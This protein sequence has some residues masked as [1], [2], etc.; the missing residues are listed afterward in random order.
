[1]AR[2]RGA[3]LPQQY[4]LTVQM[5]LALGIPQSALIIPD[6]V[7]DNTAAE[8]ATLREEAQK[9]GWKRVIVVSSAYHLRRV[10]LACR[11][12]LRG[13]GVEIE[14]HATRYDPSVPGRWW[15]RR[16]DIRWIVSELP[17]LLAYSVGA[18]A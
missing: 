13:A 8:A 17:K 9:R 1:M 18:G 11:R 3:Q 10:A 15:T 7:H 12:Q 4:Q 5:L 2:Q 14:L 6:R 16:S